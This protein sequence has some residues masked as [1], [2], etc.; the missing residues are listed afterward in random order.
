MGSL[1]ESLYLNSPRLVQKLAVAG[2]GWWWYRRR[3]SAHFHQLVHE[4]KMREGWTSEQFRQ[5]QEMQLSTLLDAAWGSPYY[6]RIFQESGVQEK[7]PPFET[8]AR[9][10]FLSK[11]TLRTNAIGLLTRAWSPKGTFVQKSSG[12]TGTPSEIYYT[13]QFHALEM[14]VPEARNLHW[15]GVDYRHRRVMFGARKVCHFNQTRPPFWRFSPVEDM[16]YASIYHLSPKFLPSYT[17]F[18]RAYRPSVIMGY[19]NALNTLARY[20]LE[21]NDLPA[22]ARVVITTSETLTETIR[23]VLEQAW[24][25]RVYDRYGAVEGCVFASQCEYNQYHV[26]PEVGIVEIVNRNGKPC[27][28]GVIG[29]AVCTGLQNTLQPLIRYRIGD[30]ARW[31]VKQ[32]CPCGRSMPIVEAIEGRFEDICFTSDGREILRFDT[33]FKGINNIKEAQVVQEGP[34]LFVV[35]VLPTSGFSQKQAERIVNNMRLHVG[36]VDV[37]VKPVQAIGRSKSG[38][39]RAVI[40]NV[41]PEVRRY[42]EIAIQ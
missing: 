2:Y 34:N 8:L 10:P 35:N 28:P 31:A 39:F 5:Y 36:D 40:C 16:A 41:P 26:S 27:L 38:K 42:S 13:P 25:C 9:L 1:S 30:A 18:L 22:P 11:E 4:F 19:P 7:T 33:V 17:S 12:T 21:N 6:R 23:H 32:D 3:F 14:A 15:A 37:E 29:E 24:Q 20:A